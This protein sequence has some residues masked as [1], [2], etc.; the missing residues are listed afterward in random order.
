MKCSK[1]DSCRILANSGSSQ[2]IN[3][4]MTSITLQVRVGTGL[5]GITCLRR[6]MEWGGRKIVVLPGYLVHRP[7][8]VSRRQETRPHNSTVAQSAHH[9]NQHARHQLLAKSARICT[10][11]HRKNRKDCRRARRHAL[12]K[13]LAHPPGP[14]HP[15]PGA[16]KK[17]KKS[18]FPHLLDFARRFRMCNLV[19]KIVDEKAKHFPQKPL[20]LCRNSTKIS[21]KIEF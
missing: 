14:D 8:G 3:S 1:P 17:K 19:G 4:P 7:H 20:L 15:L 5:Q 12:G 11:C 10:I 9:K 2:R 6:T 13:W 18:C 16:P 21:R